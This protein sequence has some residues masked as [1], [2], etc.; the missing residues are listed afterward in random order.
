MLVEF[1]FFYLCIELVVAPDLEDGWH[2]L[3]V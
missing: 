2:M 1:T 3:D